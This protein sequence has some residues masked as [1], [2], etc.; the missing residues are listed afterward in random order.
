MVTEEPPV[1]SLRDCSYVK[2]A[3]DSIERRMHPHDKTVPSLSERERL[4]AVETPL[5]TGPYERKPPTPGG[6][7]VQ[8]GRTRLEPAAKAHSGLDLASLQCRAEL[9]GGQARHLTSTSFGERS[10]AKPHRGS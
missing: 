7:P 2:T 3:C 1:W 6:G 9:R 10:N 4:A 5:Q 8:A